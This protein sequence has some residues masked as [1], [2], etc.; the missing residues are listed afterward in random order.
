[1]GS[2]VASKIAAYLHAEENKAFDPRRAPKKRL[3][4]MSFVERRDYTKVNDEAFSR[5]ICRCRDI[6]EGE[7]VEAI[8]RFPQAVVFEAVKR[9]TGAASGRCQ[10]SFCMQRIIEI[11]ARELDCSPQEI[12]KDEKGS[13]I[14]Q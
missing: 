4:E 3:N 13:Y 14:F 5:V 1:L 7:I 12:M 6:T 9:R 8:H 10:G 2:F 11:M